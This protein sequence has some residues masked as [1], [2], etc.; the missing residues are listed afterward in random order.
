M[1]SGMN[2]PP[3]PLSHLPTCRSADLPICRS[4]DLPTSPSADLPTCPPP[5]DNLL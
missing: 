1:S 5:A 3:T 2:G 4:A